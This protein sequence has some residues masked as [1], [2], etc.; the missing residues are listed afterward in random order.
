M[1]PV[2]LAYVKTHKG[3]HKKNNPC[4]VVLLQGL[5]WANRIKAVQILKRNMPQSGVSCK[6]GY[7]KF[8]RI[9]FVLRRYVLLI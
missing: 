8:I 7:L 1:H 2:V 9:I 6:R 3:L 5:Y 4:C